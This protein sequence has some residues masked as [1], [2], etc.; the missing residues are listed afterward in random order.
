MTRFNNHEHGDWGEDKIEFVKD[1]N[2]IVK[3]VLEN[4]ENC[5]QMTVSNRIEMEFLIRKAIKITEFQSNQKIKEFIEEIKRAVYSSGA[6]DENVLKH[7]CEKIVNKLTE[8]H[9]PEIHTH[10]GQDVGSNQLPMQNDNLLN[11][12]AAQTFIKELKKQWREKC[13]RME[14]MSD[15]VAILELEMLIDDITN[16]IPR[17]TKPS[18][19]QE[20]EKEL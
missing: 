11:P 7:H 14:I 10:V 18:K 20:Q 17:Q 1:Y 6:T 12:T 8:K 16:N 5:S 2:E 9:F 13:S 4:F 3:Q 15:N 19:G